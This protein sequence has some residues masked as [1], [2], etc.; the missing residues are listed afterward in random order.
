M[1]RYPKTKILK[2]ELGTTAT[3]CTELCNSSTPVK[4]KTS[5]D[6]NSEL[7]VAMIQ[8]L[9]IPPSAKR[10]EP[11]RLSQVEWQEIKRL[12]A[13]KYHIKINC[14]IKCPESPKE[15]VSMPT[16]NSKAHKA[17]DVIIHEIR[18]TR[19]MGR[20]TQG[21]LRTWTSVLSFH[22]FATSSRT[23]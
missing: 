15:Y 14:N 8:K 1:S 4:L 2:I 5:V 9:M 19:P 7:L 16:E 10:T 11:V 23:R 22:H 13:Q 20:R 18:S 21:L 12:D 6:C 3:G 17:A